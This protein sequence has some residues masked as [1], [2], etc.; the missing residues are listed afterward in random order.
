MGI[1]ELKD[2]GLLELYVI[3]DCS[4]D[5]LKIV[6]QALQKY[7]ELKKD[8]YE[9]GASLEK[10]ARLS[11]IVPSSSLKEKVLSEAKNKN[12]PSTNSASSKKQNNSSSDSTKIPKWIGSVLAIASLLLGYL[13]FDARS[14]FN[15]L[16][17][18]YER[19]IIA[20]DSIQQAA[21]MQYALN[22][23]IND[24]N[25]T[26]LAMSATDKYSETDLY[27]IYN[28][29]RQYSFLQIQNLPQISSDKSFQLW[30]I[31][32]GLDPIPL[33]V[34]QGTEGFVVPIDFE[35]GTNVY[36]ITIES[37]GGALSPNL[38]E[39]IGTVN[40]PS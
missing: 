8:L 13:Y 35:Q 40:M 38:E 39:L 12:E 15:K 37:R 28:S 10:Y 29:D 32:T 17:D 36:A 2:S 16:Q 3:G 7:P 21:Q 19:Y 23:Q 22:E 5:Q 26:L 18:D 9:I 24:S 1:K 31:K 4:N 33:T 27:I 14:E 34:F 6:E 25:N 11:S 20:C 30:S